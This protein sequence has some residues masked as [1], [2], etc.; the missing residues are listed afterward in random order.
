MSKSLQKASDRNL[1]CF[2]DSELNIM[3]L[4][5]LVGVSRASLYQLEK[6]K[7][8]EG[9]PVRAGATSKKVYSWDT[10]EKLA[11]HFSDKIIRPR[12]RKIK[13]FANLKG[14]VGKSSIS[15]QF[16]MRASAAGI[17]TL[18]IDLDP[19]A[20]ASLDL[21]Y[22][23]LHDDSPTMLNC[24]VG[25]DKV[26]IEDIIQPVTPLLSIVPASLSLSAIEVKL[27]QDYKG[28][29]KLKRVL[30]EIRDQW[31]LIIVDT[32]PSASLLNV[33]ALLAAEEICVVSATD[34][35]SVSGLRQLFSILKDLQEDFDDFGPAVRVIPNLFDV[36]EA[37][38]QEALGVLRQ[39]Y[40]QFLTNTVV[41]KNVDLKEAQKLGQAVWLYNKRSSA[42]EDI[43]SL[44]RELV[45][46]DS[47]VGV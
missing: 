35:L 7:V 47:G 2:R 24:L 22:D 31:G 11:N 14:G 12:E 32:N 28:A 36:R 20:P 10:L 4:A 5:E 44:T 43:A 17:K 30:S 41:R 18:M 26:S 23:N 39:N 8:I 40:N 19:Q 42:A 34:F 29:E 45:I 25:K 33:N 3:Q 1:P 16:A 37:M 21:G 27:Q 6:A 13:V 9:R 15:S 46:E 38:C